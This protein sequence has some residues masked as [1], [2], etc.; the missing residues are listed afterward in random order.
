MWKIQYVPV[1]ITFKTHKRFYLL[2][3]RLEVKSSYFKGFSGVPNDSLKIMR[4]CKLDK[5]L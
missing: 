2:E 1:I 5:L 4:N 3:N